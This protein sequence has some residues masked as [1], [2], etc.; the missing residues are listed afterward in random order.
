MQSPFGSCVYTAGTG[1]HIGTV[2]G[3]PTATVHVNAV[4]TRV[5]GLCPASAKWVATYTVTSPT[6]LYV[7][8]S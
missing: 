3:G 6:P 5:E 4:V 8:E 7:K 2:T 1:T